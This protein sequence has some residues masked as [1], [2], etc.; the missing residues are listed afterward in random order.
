[1]HREIYRGR[2]GLSGDAYR[3]APINKFAFKHNLY[4][5]S[6]FIAHAIGDLY[7]LTTVGIKKRG[8]NAC[9]L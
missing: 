8:Q 3:G 7:I 1:M 2:N 4:T 6:I 9:P 5:L